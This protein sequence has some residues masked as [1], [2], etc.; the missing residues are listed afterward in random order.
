[1]SDFEDFSGASSAGPPPAAAGSAD[2]FIVCGGGTTAGVVIQELTLTGR[3]FFVLEKD[4]EACE[5]LRRMVP[6]ELVLEG[7]ATDEDLLLKAGVKE[8]RGLLATLGDDKLNLVVTVTAFQINPGLRVVCLSN[9]ETQWPRLRR[10]GAI[11]VS[12]AH[13]GGRRLATGVIHPETTFFLNEMLSAPSEKPVRVEAVV[14]AKGSEGDGRSLAEVDVYAR[15][16]LQVIALCRGAA[17]EFQCNPGRETR[18][19]PEDRLLV[20]GDLHS[21]DRLA[22]LVGRWE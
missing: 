7:D 4:P 20:I 2:L 13:I 9:D 12:S 21:V 5:R 22:A 14:V 11:V 16:G 8:A 17:G 15:T 1:M 10:A 3:K 19:A 6:Q 18:L